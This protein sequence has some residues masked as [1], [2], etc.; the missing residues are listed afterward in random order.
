[1]TDPQTLPGLTPY[2]LRAGE[3]VAHLVANQI[4]R[5]VASTT[6]T[7]GG[8]GAVVC[9]CPLDRMPVPMHWHEKEHDTWF[10]TRGRLQ[11]WS[12]GQARILSPGDFAY[13][14]PGGIHS[15]QSVAPR[16]RFF[17]VVAPGGWEQFF[18]DAGEVWGM[19]A[20][21]PGDRPIP[22]PKLG[23]AI[24]KHRIMR[25]DQPDYVAP[26][27]I[28][29][30]DQALPG[31]HASYYLEAG[32][33]SRRT[34]GGHL[35]TAVLTAAE[36]DGLLEMRTV[37]GG[38]DA[39]VPALRHAATHVFLYV[40]DG[41]VEATIAGETHRLTSGDAANIPAGTAYA[42]RIA[43]GEARWIVVSSGGDG[44]AFWDRAG[45]ESRGFSHPVE[46]RTDLADRIAA[47]ADL[48]VAL[49]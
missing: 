28:G 30:A 15:Y 24:G 26:V 21:P 45:E 32:F 16:T 27:P 8:F 9:D 48:D 18:D 38:R 40:L 1:M 11:V 14:R 6:E 3:G 43:S 2:V 47:L 39:A 49:A 46:P 10:V 13:V 22:F 23:A 33:G 31:A 20:L 17:G 4:V 37:E 44:A 5:T 41:V 7:A 42:T 35:I 36:S 34:V 29:E 12:D 19:T 25:V